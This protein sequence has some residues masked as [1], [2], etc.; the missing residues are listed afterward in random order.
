VI[1]ILVGLVS[2]QTPL[3]LDIRHRG[4]ETVAESGNI[5][6]GVGNEDVAFHVASRV[7]T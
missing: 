1:T 4:Q 5:S 6:I 3:L 7:R 2:K